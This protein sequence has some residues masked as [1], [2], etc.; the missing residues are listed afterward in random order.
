M[1]NLN[2]KIY[3]FFI[4]NIDVVILVGRIHRAVCA[5]DIQTQF[6]GDGYVQQRIV[7]DHGRVVHAVADRN[8]RVEVARGPGCVVLVAEDLH[9]GVAGDGQRRSLHVHGLAE[10]PALGGQV[11]DGRV[12][13][14]VADFRGWLHHDHTLPDR[15]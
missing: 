2:F 9:A 5:V 1:N 3:M 4:L 12:H 15:S 14:E 6:L 11:T 7:D 8:D 10:V 13:V